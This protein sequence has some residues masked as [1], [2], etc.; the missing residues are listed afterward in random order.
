M[1]LIGSTLLKVNVEISVFRV[2]HMGY[3]EVEIFLHL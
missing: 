3:P 2:D 1:M